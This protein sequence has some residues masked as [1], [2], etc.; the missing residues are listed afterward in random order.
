V[1]L[2]ALIAR[3]LLAATFI[4]SAVAKLRDADG[5][6]Q[7]ARDFGV[8]AGVAPLVAASLAPLELA[9]AL[10]L[11]TMD[12]G[13]TAGAL[14]ALG[15]LA[16]FT[17]GIVANLLRGKRVDC[18]CFGAMSTKP[19]SWWSVLRN[20]SLM[21]FAAIALAGGTSQGW[22]WQV[23]AETFDDLSTTEAWLTVGVLTLAVVVAAL[24]ALFFAL[25]RRYGA[26]LLRI[27][28]L[29][30][31]GASGHAHGHGHAHEFAPWP[32]P[33]L[34]ATDASG[35][36]VTLDDVA[37]DD[38]AN[39]FVFVAPWCK[40]CG[41]LVDDLARWQADADGPNVVVLSGGERD[42][43][44]EKFGDVRVLAHDGA[45]IDDYRVEYTPG[46][47]VV[48]NDRM[49]TVT[50]AYGSD[51]VR[52]LYAQL[53]GREPQDLVIGPPPVREGDPA[54]DVI[55]EVDG[56]RRTIAEV[57]GDDSVLLF[58]DTGCGF[59]QQIEADVLR[60]QNSVPLVLVLRSDSDAAVREAGF[61]VPVALDPSFGVGG[62]L[63]APG[64]PTAVR[65]RDGEVASTVAVGGPEVL[66]LL[67]SVRVLG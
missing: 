66:N 54:P 53:A 51:D 32:A 36:A 38:R 22:P 25:L 59:C 45:P 9:S 52:R 44:A 60:R 27:E 43:I 56:E 23:V 63:Q 6:K 12:V 21:V 62:A 49:V 61:T 31:G 29:E 57:A 41:E 35:S 17:I 30:A 7:A 37:A 19:L 14:L 11:L 4:V 42:A 10:L 48:S 64:T 28:A 3:V 47:V 20:V 58:W 34:A 26:L 33:E 2:V 46:A 13:V 55:V 1:E 50:P 8:P 67:A 24:A 40:A 39:F 5:A 65:L 18:H 15:L 16:A